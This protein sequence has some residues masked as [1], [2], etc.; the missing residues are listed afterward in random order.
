[1]ESLDIVMASLI[2]EITPFHSMQFNGSHIAC[3]VD[4]RY[5]GGDALRALV[6]SELHREAFHRN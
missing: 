5:H 3:K 2:F 1:M 6:V 4:L